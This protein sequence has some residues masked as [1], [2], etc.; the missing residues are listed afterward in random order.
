[1]ITVILVM[2]LGRLKMNKL[3]LQSNLDEIVMDVN[4]CLNNLRSENQD[5]YA[6]DDKLIIILGKLCVI[7]GNL[8]NDKS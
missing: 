4:Y 6:I 2:L 3:E 5:L 7:E 1:M 8:L